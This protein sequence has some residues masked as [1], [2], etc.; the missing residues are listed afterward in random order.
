MAEETIE[1]TDGWREACLFELYKL[2]RDVANDIA[3]V[4]TEGRKKNSIELLDRVKSFS[5]Y[6]EDLIK[7]N[8]RK[9]GIL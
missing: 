1:S 8:D 2:W 4:K 5:V 9:R 7:K 6:Q 3:T